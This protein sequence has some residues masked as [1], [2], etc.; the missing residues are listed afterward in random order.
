[1]STTDNGELNK[2]DTRPFNFDDPTL[3]EV[4]QAAIDAIGKDIEQQLESGVAGQF[5]QRGVETPEAGSGSSTT[6]STVTP[7]TDA[8]P[9]GSEPSPVTPGE[10]APTTTQ[11]TTD[12]SVFTVPVPGVD[13]NTGQPYAPVTLTQ[14]QALALLQ[15]HQFY[16]SQPQETLEAWGAIQAGTHA[17]VGLQ[18]YAAFKAWEQSGR[19]AAKPATPQRPFDTDDVTPEALAYITQLEQSTAGVSQHQQQPVVDQPPHQLT[20]AQIMQQQQAEVD[21]QVALRTSLD[22][23]K[24]TLATQ[25]GLDEHQIAALEAAVVQSNVV[26]GISMKYRVM[27]P[28][29]TAVMSEGDPTTV[30][31]EAFESVMATHPTFRPIRDEA[32]F[33]ARLAK[34]AG[35]T[36][37]ANVKKAAAGS[38]AYIPSAAVPGNQGNPQ[39]TIEQMTPQ[40]RHAAMTAEIAQLIASGEARN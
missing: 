17:P 19:P 35:V 28:L 29:G 1:M 3:T 27:N 21:R 30:F 7:S 38:L 9:A 20:P 39:K 40:E 10:G 18:E 23:V 33:Q 24:T 34:N 22:H 32:L 11:Q 37:A 4:D 12:S 8:P 5:L 13:P 26:P 25:Y 2:P 36:E 6:E 31:T 16:A 15:E 14:Q